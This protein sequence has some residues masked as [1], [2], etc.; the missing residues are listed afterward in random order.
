[1]G[2]D[3]LVPHDQ[4]ME[5]IANAH[6]GIISYPLSK[7]TANS[8]PTKLYEY[9]ACNLPILLRQHPLWLEKCQPF[10]AAIPVD[11][12]KPNIENVLV[13]MNTTS[14]YTHSPEDCTWVS[15]EKKLLAAVSSL[16]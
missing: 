4:I 3:Q 16:L 7:H 15:E 1:M 10:Q 6:F 14:F 2:G 13:Q 8:L 11:F 12:M 5:Q 9:L